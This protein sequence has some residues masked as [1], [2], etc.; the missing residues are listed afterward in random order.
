MVNGELVAIRGRPHRRNQRTQNKATHPFVSISTLRSARLRPSLS[1][2]KIIIEI[3]E[4]AFRI[5]EPQQGSRG[6]VQLDPAAEDRC[7]EQHAPL[8]HHRPQM[9]DRFQLLG[10]SGLAGNAAR[11]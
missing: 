6:A 1:A 2:S 10:T 9:I 8:A 7:P 3:V 5:V 11:R 4:H